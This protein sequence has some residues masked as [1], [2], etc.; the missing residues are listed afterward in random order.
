VLA[1]LQKKTADGTAIVQTTFASG[2]EQ[3]WSFTSMGDATGFHAISP[4]SKPTSVM[5]L[6][7][8]SKTDADQAVQ[9]W[10]WKTGTNYMQWSIGLAN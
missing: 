9:E 6:P 3:L 5:S 10:T 1:V 7:S 8:A 4:L 2:T